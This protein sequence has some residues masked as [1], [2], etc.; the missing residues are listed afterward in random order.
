MKNTL[1]NED[2]LRSNYDGTSDYKIQS[3][4][5]NIKYTAKT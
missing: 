3:F 1:Q 5:I 4:N 2:R